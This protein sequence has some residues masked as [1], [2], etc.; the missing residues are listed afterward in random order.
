MNFEISMHVQVHE[1]E[2][3]DIY[4]ANDWSSVQKP[5]Q[6]MTALQHSHSLA[7]ARQDGQLIGLGN[8]ISDGH[9]VVYFP[10][11]LVHPDF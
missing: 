1:A 9:L 4:R 10:H 8:A 7:T 5:D 6:L 3:L 11:L 2:V